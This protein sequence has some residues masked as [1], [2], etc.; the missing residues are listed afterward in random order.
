MCQFIF[1]SATYTTP[2]KMFKE[3]LFVKP[4]LYLLHLYHF[5][6][7]FGLKCYSLTCHAFD[8]TFNVCAI[9]KFYI[10]KS[11]LSY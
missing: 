4:A 1:I 7:D 10:N 11:V 5:A 8:C 9:K 6:L 3:I 2:I